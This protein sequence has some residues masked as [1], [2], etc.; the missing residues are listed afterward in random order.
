MCK[1]NEA[2]LLSLETSSTIS[3]LTLTNRSDVD[4]FNLG[5]KEADLQTRYARFRLISSHNNFP[6]GFYTAWVILNTF[7][8]FSFV[9]PVGLDREQVP[10]VL[11]CLHSV[12]VGM[13]MNYTV[14]FLRTRIGFKLFCSWLSNNKENCV[15]KAL[16]WRNFIEEIASIL[17]GIST[18]LIMIMK[19]YIGPCDEHP[20]MK[21]GKDFLYCATNPVVRAARLW[22]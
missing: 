16:I 22:R 12:S 2:A 19:I 11:F 9:L 10:F 3:S 7:T 6:F 5:F 13:V 18:G 21:D 17:R 14:L 4:W 20:M 15:D 8:Y 1:G